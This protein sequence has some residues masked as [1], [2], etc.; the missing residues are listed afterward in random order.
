MILQAWKACVVHAARCMSHATSFAH[1]FANPD[2]AYLSGGILPATNSVV[3]SQSNGTMSLTI[4]GDGVMQ[5]ASSAAVAT[6]DPLGSLRTSSFQV[7]KPA[8]F[9]ACYYQ[10]YYACSS[11]RADLHSSHFGTA[12]SNASCIGKKRN[13]YAFRRQINEKPSIIPGCPGHHALLYLSG[14]SSA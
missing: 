10:F 3:P 1:D 13:D 9:W 11:A 14:H 2:A 12:F 4:L 6:I 8:T 7:C 5:N